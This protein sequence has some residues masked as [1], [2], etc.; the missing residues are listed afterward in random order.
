MTQHKQSQF[1][2]GELAVQKRLGVAESVARY[3]EGFIRSAM[4]DQHRDFFQHLP[5]VILGLVDGRGYPWALPVF[6][7]PSAKEAFI[8]S[9]DATRLD[10][11]GIA[12]SGLPTLIDVLKLDVNH[13]Q[14]V[15]MLGIEL[16]TRRRNRLNGVLNHITD[17]SFSID[18]EQSFGNCPQYIQTRELRWHVADNQRKEFGEIPI[19]Q[20]IDQQS[21]QFIENTDTF[22]IASRTKTF[23]TDSRTGI[24]A[25]H[26]GGKPGF[27]KVE[28]NTLYFPD[29]SGNRFFNTLG[30]IESDGRVGVFFPDFTTGNSI[31]ISGRAS[32]IWE[33]DDIKSFDGA[34]RF[35]KISVKQCVRLEKFMPITGELIEPSP[36]LEKT[37]TWAQGDQSKNDVFQN[38]EITRKQKESDTITSFYLTP[39]RK[40]VLDD[41]IPGQFLPVRL[42]DNERGQNLLRS[43]TLSRAPHAESYRIS[44]KR[45]E[46]G[47]ASQLLH[48]H[49]QVGNIIK[50]GKPAGHFTLQQNNHAIVFI[51]GGVGITPMMAMLEGIIREVEQGKYPHS[52][53][54]PVWFIHST[55]NAQSQAFARQLSAWEQR[56]P[57]LH[58][59][60]AY[61][62]PDANDE[63]GKTHQ[64]EGRLSIDGLK[65]IL[66]FDQYDFYLC[67]SEGFMRTLYKGLVATGVD[68]AQIFYEFFGAGSIEDIPVEHGNNVEQ[69]NKAEQ[70]SNAIASQA[71]IH[72]S[73]SGL[74]AQ[75]TPDKGTLLEFAEQ[76]GLQPIYSC[77]SG[78]CGACA[79]KITSGTVSYQQKLGVTP[80]NGEV[81]LCSARP[82]QGEE[83]IT[84]VI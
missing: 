77:R 18:V 24:D 27:V 15:G 20:T 68:R 9:P 13:G 37:G 32:V 16:S 62:N 12:A 75:W 64:S 4:P 40:K 14:K 79:C 60:T 70:G 26:R 63:L 59:H 45:E 10:I 71:T 46:Q 56:Y 2:S 69:D 35:I 31:F 58:I 49:L 81:L 39:L 3:S 17:D 38:V 82:A 53:P 23:N 76:Q 74:S 67:G 42:A 51:S 36:V 6:D 52:G 29:F 84:L 48:D 43:Y 22:F 66:P 47:E 57:W 72:F 5:F 61:S 54:R 19:S 44:V 83:E 8:D 28:D 30:N 34:E 55:R 25:S 11:S 73:D 80:A 21:Q 78:Q 1:H 41:Y 33:T 65:S 50:V 7:H